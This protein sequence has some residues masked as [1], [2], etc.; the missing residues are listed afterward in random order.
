MGILGRAI[1]LGVAVAAAAVSVAVMPA[2]LSS[3][4]GT[5]PNI[6]FILTDDQRWDSLWAMPHVRALLGAHGVTFGSMFVVNPWWWPSRTTYLTG[7]YSHTTSV[8]TVS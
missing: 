3:A 4:A 1:R 6:V 8:Y 7:D 2:P 5:K